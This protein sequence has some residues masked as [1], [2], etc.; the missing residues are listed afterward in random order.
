MAKKEKA[1]IPKANLVPGWTELVR[2]FSDEAKFWH[3]IWI[4]AGKS[5]Y[6]VL[7]HITKRTRNKYHYAIR[8]C[9]RASEKILKDKM[10]ENITYLT[11]F[12]TSDE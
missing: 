12:T 3:A 10:L 9:K 5:L 7:H 11:K 8:K 4:S 2:L 6:T 1:N